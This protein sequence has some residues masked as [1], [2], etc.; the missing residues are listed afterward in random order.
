VLALDHR[1]LFQ[2]ARNEKEE[3]KLTLPGLIVSSFVLHFT[4]DQLEESRIT[5]MDIA[6][7]VSNGLV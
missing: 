5:L 7:N 1:L 3:V 6:T 4:V 2:W